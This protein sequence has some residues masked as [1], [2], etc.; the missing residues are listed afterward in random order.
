MPNKDDKSV[1]KGME[2]YRK[3]DTEV[4]MMDCVSCEKYIKQALQIAVTSAREE[5]AREIFEELDNNC[6]VDYVIN[7]NVECIMQN[8]QKIRNKYIKSKNKKVD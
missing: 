8:Y 7:N 2:Y 6:G 5:T 3:S 4:D 1:E